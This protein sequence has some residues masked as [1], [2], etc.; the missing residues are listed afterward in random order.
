MKPHLI[1]TV[2]WRIA[3]VTLVTLG[4]Q[5]QDTLPDLTKLQLE[6]LMN[7]DVTSA[8]K[9]QQK[10]SNVPAAIFVISREDIRRSGATSI[11]DLLRIVP[12]LE[13]A[14]VNPSTWAITA[15]GFN[16][17]Y[18]NKLLV[19]VDGRSVYTP[20]FGGVFWDHQATPLALVERIEVIRGP[21]AAIWGANAVNGV[22]NIITRRAASTQG[23]ALLLQAG[24]Q[25][26][27]FGVGRYG[28]RI[29][30]HGWYRMHVDAMETGDNRTS[31]HPDAQDGWRRFQAG[32]RADD[33]LTNQDDLTV[34]GQVVRGSEGELATTIVSFT[35]PLT[36]NLGLQNIFFN[37][38]LLGRW[39]HNRPTGSSTSLQMYFDRFTRTDTTVGGGQNT[40]DLDFQQRLL[41]RRHDVVWGL[42]YRYTSD[43]LPA[44]WRIAF[45]PENL[46]ASVFNSFLQDDIT[47]A[48]DRLHV[49]LGTKLEH[50]YYNGWNLQPTVRA[51]WTPGERA[52]L[53]AALSY[54]ERTPT[55][56][57]TGIR[58]NT[59]A[60]PGPDQVPVLTSLFGTPDQQNEHL[61][62]TEA[63]VRRQFSDRVTFDGSAFFN[64]YTQLASIEQGPPRLE[65]DPSPLH[66]LLPFTFANRLQGETH[67]LELFGQL[68]LA[69]RWT[70]SPGYTFLAMHL[71]PLPPASGA[72]AGLTTTFDT[73]GNAPTQQAQ[74]RS[75]VMLQ[76]Q[77]QWGVT[78][79]FV[80]RLPSPRLPSYTRLDSQLTWRPSEHLSLMLVGQNL[81][82]KAHQE[83][84][85][86]ELTVTPSLVPRSAFA[87]LVWR[88]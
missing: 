53:W 67:G 70:L 39:K 74:L 46:G 23:A 50:E 82:R 54:A 4:A 75:T 14:E 49:I 78:G 76:R 35:P 40:L 9:K 55:R 68:K 15:R 45:R 21:G 80:G 72:N 36:K 41:H 88:Y 33:D 84:A 28:G 1:R 58:W 12:G 24:S 42:G 5:G 73:V 7:L 83:Y 69:N 22:V 27:G 65:T 18:S 59:A 25:E 17:Q 13:V 11:P 81:L 16:G 51:A 63:G 77:W 37:W 8:A 79:Y 30:D 38:S 85:D 64:R 86:P 3:L 31:D 71:R 34:Q 20:I 47:V 62:A 61:T 48:G 60:Y 87:R 57:E 19:L 66:I 10:L 56:T 32:F 26:H 43:Q 52:T 2:A 44:L 29:G 6:D